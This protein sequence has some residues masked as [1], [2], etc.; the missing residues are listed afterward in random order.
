MMDTLYYYVGPREITDNTSLEASAKNISSIND[1]LQWVKE[2]NQD[3]DDMNQVT[4][5]FII[6]QNGD[7]LISDRH[8]EHVACA[9]GAPVL[10]AGEISFQVSDNDVDV[11]HVTNQS[12]GYCPEPKSW[13]TVQKVLDKVGL[14][15]PPSFTTAFEFRKCPNCETINII[16]D[17]FYYCAVCDGEL[18]AEWNFSENT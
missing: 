4:A 1:I 18:P 12:T 6:D 13:K 17:E 3:L 15:H 16:K 14:K 9:G 7:L 8:S 10:S 11:I 2:T 5:S